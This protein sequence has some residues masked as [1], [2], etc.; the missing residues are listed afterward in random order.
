[1]GKET[2]EQLHDFS[3]DI[4][5]YFGLGCRNVS[6]VLVPRTYD[7]KK[8]LAIF[9][10]AE[11]ELKHH[12]KYKNNY[13]YQL[14]L[15][16]INQ[17]PHFASENLLICENSLI[18]SPIA[19]LYY[20]HYDNEDDVNKYIDKNK[21]SIQCIVANNFNGVDS[22]NFGK[23]QSPSLYDY[24]DNIDMMNFLLNGI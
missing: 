20:E 5:N 12:H 4:S 6:K 11:P 23:S 21:S 16:L 9:E 7:F 17:T 8:L 15:L 1:L 22:V 18:A 24:A 14:S 10:N 2:E 13:D 19:C 3:K